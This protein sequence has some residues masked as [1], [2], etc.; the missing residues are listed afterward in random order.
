MR[1][2]LCAG[3]AA[4]L[5]SAAAALEARD[6]AAL[7]R[8]GE[9]SVGVFNPLVVGL[10]DTIELETHPLLLVGAPNAIVRVRQAPL[11]DWRLATEFGLSLPTPAMRLAK[12]LGLSGD[13]FPSCKVTADDA[14]QAGW[15]EQPGWILVPRLG[16]VA[17]RG[18]ETVWTAKADV[19]AGLLLSGERGHPLDALP[20]IDLLFAPALNGWRAHVGGRVDHALASI[21]S[22]S[23][24]SLSGELHGYLVG[25]S[26]DRNPFTL[27]A[28]AGV[29]V[30]VGAAS[31]F[32]LGVMYWNSDQRR[33]VVEK[34]AEGFST[35][36]HVRSND[37]FP[38]IDFIWSSSADARRAPEESSDAPTPLPL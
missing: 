6:T 2:Y 36:R 15:C 32:T 4:L 29:D 27:A 20:A 38:T 11:G 3:L 37:F 21:G 13:L 1:A 26:G 30:A 24:V 5:S 23:L 19:A 35:A 18:E 12:P 33:V 17:S 31:R 10:T 7:H 8:K 25:A 28:H 9:W 22:R 34:G 14:A 16:L